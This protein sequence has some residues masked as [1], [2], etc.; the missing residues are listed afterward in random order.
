MRPSRAHPPARDRAR[1]D[2]LTGFVRRRAR[3]FS[4][5]QVISETAEMVHLTLFL[6]MIIYLVSVVVLVVVGEQIRRRW[7]R[8]EQVDGADITLL[9]N[10]F[11]DDLCYRMPPPQPLHSSWRARLCRPHA[12]R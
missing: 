2:A 7:Y 4:R 9:L 8:W 11:A 12:R 6:I 1:A 5:A 3:A 10:N